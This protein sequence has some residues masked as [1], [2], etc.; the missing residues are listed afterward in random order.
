M[1]GLQKIALA[2]CA[3][4]AAVMALGA[5]ESTRQC[6]DAGGVRLRPFLGPWECYDAASL[7]PA[8][9]RNN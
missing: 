3:S 2:A 5:W 4:I 7:R 1:T 9:P 6:T 8:K